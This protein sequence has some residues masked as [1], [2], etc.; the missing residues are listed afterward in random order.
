MPVVAALVVQLFYAIL[1]LFVQ[2]SV[3]LVRAG[4][5]LVLRQ[6]RKRRAAMNEEARH[7][8]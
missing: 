8:P 1:F 7:D 4:V 3:V 5:L 6:R 2:L